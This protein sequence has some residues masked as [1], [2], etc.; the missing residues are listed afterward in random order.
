MGGFT[1]PPEAMLS[2]ASLP[3]YDTSPVPHPASLHHGA[4]AACISLITH[5]GQPGLLATTPPVSRSAPF[6]LFQ[7]TPTSRKSYPV[8]CW[9]HFL[10]RSARSVVPNSVLM[11]KWNVHYNKGEFLPGIQRVWQG[12]EGR[13]ESFKEDFHEGVC[14]AVMSFS[15]VL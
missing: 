2:F 12:Q 1:V 14:F 5:L 11:C 7:T 9:P 8:H 15:P 6:S 3:P 4:P 13:W 10:L